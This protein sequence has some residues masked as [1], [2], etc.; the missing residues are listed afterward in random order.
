MHKYLEHFAWTYR[1]SRSIGPG[2]FATPNSSPTKRKLPMLTLLA[3]DKIYN[4]DKEHQ[5]V[6][7]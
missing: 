1:I 2:S 6:L 4:D 7:R 3:A 5:K